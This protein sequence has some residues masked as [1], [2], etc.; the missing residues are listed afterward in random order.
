M[1][2]SIFTDDE[3]SKSVFDDEGY[4]L[5]HQHDLYPHENWY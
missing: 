2:D 4:A 3:Y 1:Q 5:E